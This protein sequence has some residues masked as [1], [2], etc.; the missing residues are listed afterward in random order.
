MLFLPEDFILS[1]FDTLPFPVLEGGCDEEHI[2]TGE[3]EE[4]PD[5]VGYE[6]RSGD[7]ERSEKYED[8]TDKFHKLI[9]Y[10]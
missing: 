2:C 5:D 9:I 3:D 8:Y 6:V 4:Y 10:G 1:K 7:D